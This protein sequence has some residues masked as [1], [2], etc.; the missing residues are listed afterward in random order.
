MG[1]RDGEVPPA[2]V[3]EIPRGL[4]LAPAEDLAYRRVG[5][6]EP[7]RPFGLLYGAVH[8]RRGALRP[9]PA[10]LVDRGRSQPQLGRGSEVVGLRTALA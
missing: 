8:V 9:R 7:H 3:Q 10:S 6:R 5:G 1:V 4:D 2:G